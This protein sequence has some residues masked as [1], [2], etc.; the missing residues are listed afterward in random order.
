MLK[1]SSRSAKLRRLCTTDLRVLD[2]L[3]SC[4]RS[5]ALCN[6]LNIRTQK[7]FELLFKTV[8][9]SPLLLF[10]PYRV[11]IDNNDL[12]HSLF[13]ARKSYRI[14]P[15]KITSQG[16]ERSSLPPKLNPSETTPWNNSIPETI[17][18]QTCLRLLVRESV[19]VYDFVFDLAIV[20][21][22]PY[23]AS[24]SNSRTEGRLVEQFEKLRANNGGD[25]QRRRRYEDVPDANERFNA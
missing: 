12:R 5:I 14:R 9:R 18:Q 15:R 20:F 3:T 4:A 16:V 13:K 11:S 24:N 22:V 10:I 8:L 7:I 19:Y 2:I 6:N 23:S 1:I 25:F 21:Q 17:Y